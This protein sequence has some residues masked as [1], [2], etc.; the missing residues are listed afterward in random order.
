MTMN[1][2][3]LKYTALTFN[4]ISTQIMSMVEN[5][6]DN[7]FANLLPS[8]IFQFCLD[9]FAA[10]ADMINFQIERRAEESYY[11]Y[12]KLMSS[13]I[14]LSRQF[15]YDVTR[16]QPARAKIKM[17]INCAGLSSIY[18]KDGINLI[19]IPYLAKFSA[20]GN[21]FLLKKTFTY[22]ID[23]DDDL[24]RLIQSGK[25][26]YDIELDSNDDKIEIVQG[27]I[28]E[29]MFEGKTSN[30]INSK[31]Q[32]YKITDPEFS[33]MFGNKDDFA[34]LVTTVYVGSHK[35]MYNDEDNNV[36]SYYM[37]DRRSLINWTNASA[38]IVGGF[39]VCLIR[40]ALD[41]GVDVMFGDTGNGE[42]GFASKGAQTSSDN[43]Y[44]Q[45]LSCSGK[46]ANTIGVVGNR[47]TTGSPVYICGVDRSDAVVFELTTN[48]LGGSNIEDIESIKNFS[49]KIYYSL[50]RL[51]SKSDYINYLKTLKTPIEV[52]NAL[53]WGEQEQK[54]P[55]AFADVKSFNVAFF[56]VM[57]SLYNFDSAVYRPKSD[58][59]IDATAVLD[60]E[61]SA[62]GI[63]TQ[64]LFNVYTRKYIARQIKNYMAYTPV[65]Q[66]VIY[67]DWLD[68]NLGGTLTFT[69]G[70]DM[71]IEVG[72]DKEYNAPT[73]TASMLVKLAGKLTPGLPVYPVA[74]QGVLEDALNDDLFPAKDGVQISDVIKNDLRG[75]PTTNK[76]YG[77]K[78]FESFLKV[79]ADIA[80]TNNNMGEAT[81]VRFVIRV[82]KKSPGYIT[83]IESRGSGFLRELGLEGKTSVLEYQSTVT[84]EI[85]VD[86]KLY[87]VLEG[88]NDRSQVTVDNVYATPIIHKVGIYGTVY[89]KSLNDIITT[90][91]E[92]NNAIYKHLDL[93]ADF[94]AKIPI[95]DITEIIRKHNSVRW[96]DVKFGAIVRRDSSI[97]PSGDTF[98]TIMKKYNLGQPNPLD[99][100]MSWL[101]TSFDRIYKMG[102]S[103][104]LI[105]ERFYTDV[106]LLA[107]WNIIVMVIKGENRGSGIMPYAYTSDNPKDTTVI[108]LNAAQQ[109]AACQ[110]I[111][112]VNDL[113]SVVLVS[114]SKN[115]EATPFSPLFNSLMARI[116]DKFAW[117]IATGLINDV[118]N[119]GI[120]SSRGLNGMYSMGSEIVQI[121][122]SAINYIY[123]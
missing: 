8:Q 58:D 97:P 65:Y 34:E 103:T 84:S 18:N 95:S 56:T 35:P 92:I 21:S 119:I 46:A 117:R 6:P 50:D 60:N 45:Y 13:V 47:V 66:H 69:T 27:V 102:V 64:S 88:L 15:G 114:G 101:M 120:K 38:P 30:L 108:M 48:I 76:N 51:V 57:G 11:E 68:L 89:V 105:T 80:Y 24:L 42:T 122:C 3:P 118:G 53:A 77:K 86:G 14:A 39:N 96:S 111:F 9:M 61:Y 43:V 113:E 115:L 33:N 85:D 17:K 90:K 70:S 19:Q 20:E 72:S 109:L 31:F 63:N 67:G 40:T 83:Q 55:T 104:T 62:A 10:V 110:I 41:G 121:D 25:G 81:K 59:E 93:L 26:T 78:M 32:N 74:I 49:P 5:D 23:L 29:R 79:K 99:V 71:F 52:K 16:P 100:D 73:E 98:F 22:N 37:I 4:D 82:D 7:R 123:G 94:N 75:S 54:I 116:H 12:A 107:M 1:K 106:L 91:T 87:T 44:V 2:N 28:R 112:G 36:G